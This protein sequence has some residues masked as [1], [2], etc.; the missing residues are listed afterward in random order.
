M[1]EPK[2]HH[3]VP[4]SLLKRFSIRDE[5]RQVYVF[6][7]ATRRAY[8]AAIN[9]AGAENHFYSVEIG[10]QR[11]VLEHLFNDID[12]EGA[13]L[14]DKICQERSLRILSEDERI[15]LCSVAA[16]QLLRVKGPREDLIEMSRHL[17]D[18]LEKYGGS[19]L[20][21]K[22]HVM[23][24]RQAR[25]SSMHTLARLPFFAAPFLEKDLVLISSGERLFF[26]GDNPIITNNSFPYGDLGLSSPGVEIYFPISRNLVCGFYCR[27][28]RNHLENFET[29]EIRDYQPLLEA[30]RSGEPF[31]YSSEEVDFLN[32]L[33]VLRSTQH[34]YAT[35]P[36]FSLAV[37]MFDRS[38][39]LARRTPSIQAGFEGYTYRETMPMGTFVVA[40]GQ[41]SH[42][43]IPAEIA[44]DGS[45]DCEWVFRT[46]VPEM[47]MAA[48]EDC[49]F[50]EVTLFVDQRM[51]RQ[52]RDVIFLIRDDGTVCVRMR[53]ESLHRLFRAIDRRSDDGGR[54][55]EPESKPQA[56]REETAR[57][58]SRKGLQEFIAS[59]RQ[60]VEEGRLPDSE[61]QELFELEE[62]LRNQTQTQWENCINFLERFRSDD[63]DPTSSVKSGDPLVQE[64]VR[65]FVR[66][67]LPNPAAFDSADFSVDHCIA[68]GEALCLQ[69]TE[70]AR[71]W[72]KIR[73]L[74]GLAVSLSSGS[75]EYGDSLEEFLSDFGELQESESLGIRLRRAV[76]WLYGDICDL[77][78]LSREQAGNLAENTAVTGRRI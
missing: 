60:L 54:D 49:P 20:D 5:G 19:G 77:I 57:R 36:D 2:K 67:R 46:S 42:C 22:E 31:E 23:S 7:K 66:T 55:P 25:V 52:I 44:D 26:I 34:L 27:S 30:I 38:P 43:M 18:T 70:P 11:L 50:K 16:A 72:R 48:I 21:L 75:A 64:K 59:R 1:V 63:S 68:L 62:S 32:E 56:P 10:D 53:D 40:I 24:D 41:K 29:W 35:E 33:Q 6:D 4:R 61:L 13:T 73:R 78:E 45:E 12:A 17:I 3:Y 8:V 51:Q 15:L 47:V 76:S 39:D 65:E 14:L 74:H 37:A 58:F 71:L 69:E 28:I 9:D